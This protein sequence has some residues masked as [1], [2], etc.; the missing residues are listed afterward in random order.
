VTASL[1]IRRVSFDVDLWDGGP[2]R[3][4]TPYVDRV[5]LVDL[6][7]AYE[8]A[9]GYDIP[10][11]YAGLVVDHFD[12]GDLTAYLTGREGS[13]ALL[14]CDCGDVGCWPFQA[15]VETGK[16]VT[17]RAFNQPHRP[18]RDYTCFGPFTFDRSQ[19]DAAVRRAVA[20]VTP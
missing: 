1:E 18:K 16:H 5:S 8:R 10:C 15:R 6:V 20:Q 11:S 13:V 12:Y 9:A 4:L 19:Y 7:S 2:A 14:G 3:A 17:W